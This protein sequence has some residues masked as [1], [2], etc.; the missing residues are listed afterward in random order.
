MHLRDGAGGAE[1]RAAL[2]RMRFELL[3]QL[4]EHARVV[5]CPPSGGPFLGIAAKLIRATMS[6]A[7]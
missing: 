6:W 1:H 5:F 2:Q 7:S 4:R 3:A